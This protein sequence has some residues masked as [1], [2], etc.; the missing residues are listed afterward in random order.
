MIPKIIHYCWFGKKP[1][2]KKTIKCI[3]SW[4]KYFPDFEIKEWNE[5]NFD[6]SMFRY[7]AEAYS[8]KKWAFV[9]D[10]ARL[11]ALYREGGIYFDTDVEVIRSFD[12]LLDGKVVFGLEDYDS[13]ATCVMITPKGFSLFDSLISEYENRSFLNLDGT[14]DLTPNP[15]FISKRI[16]EIGFSLKKQEENANI[17]ILDVEAFSPYDYRG[18]LVKLTNETYSIHHFQA[19]WIPKYKI[20]DKKKNKSMAIKF[21]KK[22]KS[23]CYLI[24]QKMISIISRINP[25]L[26]AVLREHNIQIRKS[27]QLSK[28]YGGKIFIYKNTNIFI[29]SS[30][31]IE[32]N[33][34]LR[35]GCNWNNFS[36]YLT[37]FVVGDSATVMVNGNFRI[38]SGARVSVNNNA[39][40]VLGDNGLC[41]LCCNIRC[42]NSI[43]IG[44][45]V[46]I[47]ENCVLSDSDNHDIY[48]EGKETPISMPIMIKDHALI[49][50]NCTIL[51]GVTINNDSVIAAGSVVIKDVPSRSI[52]GG[53]PAKVIKSDISWS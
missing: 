42:F 32:I 14:C 52:T 16:K 38:L 4:R 3:K 37:N 47:S 17:R 41:N 22:V 34:I 43:C 24:H 5:T 27:Y 40:L 50:L 31:N 36:N 48:Y 23:I 44:D 26:G 28:R 29:N 1:L 33:G 21:L 6:V 53:V 46:R 8:E 51:K 19:S 49:G 45:N 10:V 12:N 7:T 39:R 13:I 2:D 18:N 20:K 9:S 30:A 25:L 15:G 35:I 11:Y